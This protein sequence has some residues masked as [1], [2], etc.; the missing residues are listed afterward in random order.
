[1]GINYRFY[2]VVSAFLLLLS[3]T[4]AASAASTHSVDDQFTLTETQI[5]NN[6]SDQLDPAIYRDRI[7]WQD[8]RNGNWDIYIY[9]LSTSTESRITTDELDQINPAIYGDRIVW[10]DER[11]GNWDIY[12]Y[13]LSTQKET[14]ITDE[15]SDQVNPSIYKDRI[16]WQDGRNGNWD[17]YMYDLSTQ[18]ETQITTDKSNQT[19]PVIYEDRI[20]WQD[21]REGREIYLHDLSTSRRLFNLFW[22]NQNF[23]LFS[24]FTSSDESKVRKIIKSFTSSEI[25]ITTYENDKYE[26][27]AIYGNKVVW[28]DRLNT[29]LDNPINLD[30][31]NLHIYGI[32]MYDVSTSTKTQ[33]TIGFTSDGSCLFP[34]IYGDKIVWQDER[35]RNSDI[36]MYDLSTSTETRITTNES[37]QTRPAIYGDSIVWQ[38]ERNGNADIYMCT[39]AP[40]NEKSLFS[41]S[42]AYASVLNLSFILK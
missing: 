26:P 30:N 25:S 37:S 34:A 35:A 22:N 11:N 31:S 9:N 42:N 6:E 18:K 13:D 14:Q 7:V 20:V 12:V 19:K 17:I 36:Y 38:D 10:Q 24:I 39:L 33:I 16:V 15:L 8:E 40:A 29:S 3:I 32:Y 41:F 21:E 1:M 28:A 2:L 5:T 4:S 23:D 27:A